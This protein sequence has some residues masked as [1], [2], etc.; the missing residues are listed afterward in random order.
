MTSTDS[1]TMFLRRVAAAIRAGRV[2]GAILQL[3]RAPFSVSSVEWR[4]AQDLLAELRGHFCAGDFAA[5]SD[6]ADAIAPPP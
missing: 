2:A 6:F 5:I 3:E 4:N 1:E